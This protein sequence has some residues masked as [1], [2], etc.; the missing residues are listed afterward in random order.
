[1]IDG[2]IKTAPGVAAGASIFTLPAA[3]RPS[4]AITRA[5]CSVNSGGVNAV[6]VNTSGVVQNMYTVA[7]NDILFI[8]M[9]FRL[10]G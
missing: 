1:M 6:Q 4:L 3:Y 2:A 5:A 9:S 10:V 8:N 7:A